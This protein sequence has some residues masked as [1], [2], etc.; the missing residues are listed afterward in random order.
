MTRM[1]GASITRLSLDSRRIVVVRT[2]GTA[3]PL[4]VVIATRNP[5][6]LIVSTGVKLHDEKTGAA[7]IEGK[8]KDSAKEIAMQLEPPSGSR[9]GFLDFLNP[10]RKARRLSVSCEQVR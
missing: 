3:V 4:A 8:A 10:S 1:S 9:A 7:T 6:G 5:L 2:S